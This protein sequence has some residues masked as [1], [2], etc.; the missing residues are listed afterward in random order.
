LLH[1]TIKYHHN[2]RLGCPEVL[3]HRDV[4]RETVEKLEKL[5]QNGHSPSSALKTLKY[6]LHAGGAG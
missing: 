2:H 1:V 4:A 5:F 6:D 3:Q